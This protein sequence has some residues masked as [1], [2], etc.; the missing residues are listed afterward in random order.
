MANCS[1]VCVNVIAELHE[2]L[3][4]IQVKVRHFD[5]FQGAEIHLAL[6]EEQDLVYLHPA[7]EALH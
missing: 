5:R 6:E 1:N 7:A 3:L 4:A 2:S